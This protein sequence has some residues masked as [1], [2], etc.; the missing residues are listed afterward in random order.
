MINGLLFQFGLPLNF[1][2]TVYSRELRQSL[3]DMAVLFSLSTLQNAVSSPPDAKT[4]KLSG[5]KIEFNDVSFY[6]DPE[7]K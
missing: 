2:G 4:L 6:Y 3:L 5:G 7:K 1:L